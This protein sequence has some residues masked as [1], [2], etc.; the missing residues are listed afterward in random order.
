M[1]MNLTLT[2]KGEQQDLVQTPTHITYMC[3]M[4]PDGLCGDLT[5]VDAKRAL[6]CYAEY[7]SSLTNGAWRTPEELRMLDSLRHTQNRQH[8]IIKEAL[9]NLDDVVVSYI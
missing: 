6:F 2:I 4:T 5:G 3:C 8:L 9:N 1:S 7:V